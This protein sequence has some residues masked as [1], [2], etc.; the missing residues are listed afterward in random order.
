MEFVPESLIQ[1][2]TNIFIVSFLFWM[3]F[4]DKEA[5]HPVRRHWIPRVQLPFVW[6]GLNATWKMFAPNPPLRTIWPLARLTMRNG[7]VISWEPASYECLSPWR[8]VKYKK[9]HK[10]YF[11]VVRPNSGHQ[12]KRDFVEHLLRKELHPES[13][14]KVEVFLVAQASPPFGGSETTPPPPQ[15]QLI[16]TFHPAP[17]EAS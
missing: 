11:E 14:V 10:Y 8:K 13:C 9:F 6:L 12:I 15:K 4:W 17:L 1:I 16:Y 7:D 2:F 3:I 5:I